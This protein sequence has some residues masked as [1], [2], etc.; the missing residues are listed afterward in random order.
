LIIAQRNVIVHE[1]GEIK[2][3]RIWALAE[4]RIP[5][6]VELIKPLLPSLG[7]LPTEKELKDELEREK[8]MLETEFKLLKS[9]GKK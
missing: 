4:N 8:R 1:Y 3:D 9:K 5:E 7:Y 6:L 2:Q